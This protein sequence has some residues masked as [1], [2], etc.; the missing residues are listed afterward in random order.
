MSRRGPQTP[1]R[2]LG[3]LLALLV[4]LLLGP[5]ARADPSPPASPQPLT[6]TERP[7]FGAGA[8]AIRIT[9]FEPSIPG[10]Q[11]QLTLRG[12]I[13]N[14][15]DVPVGS[16]SARLRVSPTPLANR[17]EVPEVLAGIGQRTGEPI[18]GAVSAQVGSLSPGQSVPFV[19]R[20]A[21]ADLGLGTAGAYVTGAEA[22]G[23]AGAGRV[24][25]DLDRTFLPWWP[26]DTEI[27]PLGL[28]TLWPMTGAPLRDAEGVLLSE[29]PAVELSPSGRLA[30]LLAASAGTS[31]SMVLDPQVVDA[32]ADLADGYLVRQPDGS[33]APGTRSRE[34]AS[35]LAD[36]QAKVTEP[37]A[38]VTG[39]LYAWPDVDAVRRGRLLT[40]VLGQRTA[41]SEVTEQVLDR[42]LPARLVLPPA[43]VAQPDT[44][45]ALAR[46]GVPAIVLR[47]QALP[48]VTPTYFTPSGTA[49]VPT[50][51]G[52]LTGLL[53]DS[54]LSATLARPMDTPA[55]VAAARQALLA[56]TL[57]IAAE[58]PGTERLL[59]TSP[60]PGWSP[61]EP[62]ARMV[63]QALTEPDWLAP[64]SLSAALVSDSSS[65]PRQF[66]A[67]TEE[68]AAQ[69]L[70]VEH[71]QRV[72]GQYR[73]LEEYATVVSDGDSIPF[74]THTAPSRLLGAWFRSHPQ[75]SDE[76]TDLVGDQTRALVDSVRVVSSGSVTVSGAS[77]TLP[78][79]VENLGPN[80][81]TIGL[82]LRSTP[83]QLVT[84]APIEPFPIAPG[85]R[86]SVEVTAQV[87]AAG[88][89]A[90][91]I[92]MVTAG[93][94]PFGTAGELVVG[95][96]A[97]ADAA[98]V[99]VQVALGALVLAVLVHGIRRARRRRGT[100]AVPPP[101]EP[102]TTPPERRGDRG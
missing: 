43:G 60:E 51:R 49:L 46:G 38:D 6:G 56:E 98:R 54:G 15:A 79:T 94:A 7:A 45:S 48:L 66:V 3:F 64:T 27:T 75:D 10:P 69:E 19:L 72:R 102:A 55:D 2:A 81:V 36:L 65:L 39:S 70:P 59:I 100:R 96:A 31:V 12:T 77:G 93:G 25:Q 24:R 23:D 90:V 33:A 80:A 63:A 42:R 57:V 86:T 82:V 13:T 14:T 44:L 67:P 16:V 95:S 40:R 9:G 22:L 21:V 41:V 4:P 47:D 34:A 83:P 17:D 85:R 91:S 88:P 84:A 37:R 74:V 52:T 71:V 8:L 99:L 53:L 73:Y 32:A 18:A 76:L 62:A 11:D 89:V 50:S 87:A 68:Q 61:T 28:T 5:A 92:Q 35:W 26:A 101:V 78:I 29:E 1:V 30:N 58:L 97:Y 20:A